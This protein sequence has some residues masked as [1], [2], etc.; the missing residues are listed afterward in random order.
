[1]PE[2]PEVETMRRMVERELVGLT[3]AAIDLRLPKLTRDSPLPDLGL[4]VG[5]RVLAARRRAKVLV[6]DWSDSLSTMTHFKLAGQLAIDRV[7][8]ER[9]IAGHPVPQTDGPLPHKSTH[10]TLRFTDG[11]I[12]YYS[13]IRQ[14][15]WW[16]L[17]P[18]AAVDAALAAFAF[19]PEGAGSE[20]ISLPVLGERL[21]KRRIPI[22]TALLDQKVVAGL[23]NIY[24]DEALHR[25]RLHPLWPAN[26]LTSD[27]LGRLHE[28]IPW[29][30][31]R[32]IEQG[33]A[34]IIRGRA[35]PIEGFPAVHGRQGEICDTC[36]TTIVKTRVGGRGTYLCPVCQPLPDR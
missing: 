12:A 20:A 32:G 2:L 33:G 31:E 16:R 30:L 6:I 19:G 35:H 22:K 14:F 10:L 9:I 5:H 34:K 3:L 36:G 17:L 11:T 24:V 29:V 26:S 23:G 7:S 25:A 27:E 28:A 15:G 18:T 4:L 13:D 21:A 8:G 1:M